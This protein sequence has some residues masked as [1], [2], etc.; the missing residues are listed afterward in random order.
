MAPKA[1]SEVIEYGATNDLDLPAA[2]SRYAGALRGK[3]AAYHHRW[4]LQ[5]MRKS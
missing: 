2:D 1:A 4:Y 3:I 5:K